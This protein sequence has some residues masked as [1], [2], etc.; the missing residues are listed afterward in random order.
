VASM[1]VAVIS[2]FIVSLVSLGVSAYLYGK[3]GQAKAYRIEIETQLEDEQVLN[4]QVSAELGEVESAK[5]EVETTLLIREE[6]MAELEIETESLKEREDQLLARVTER[7]IEIQALHGELERSL[8]E[9]EA[10]SDNISLSRSE[11]QALQERLNEARL[12]KEA[13]EERFNSTARLPAPVAEVPIIDFAENLPPVEVSPEGVE[14]EKIVVKIA[15]EALEGRILV[16]NKEFNFV[17]TN[18]GKR[19]ELSLGDT[20]EI[21]RQ[22][23]PIGHAQIEKLYE[24]MSAATIIPEGKELEIREGDYVRRL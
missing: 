23:E 14:L 20:L 3:K 24:S 15:S 5:K 2:I 11:A 17:I 16:V 4:A 8:S 18:M 21:V 19:D 10:L 12:A 13:L 6:E 1:R 22:D 9:Q 7:E